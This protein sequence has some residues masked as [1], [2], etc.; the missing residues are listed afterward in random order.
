MQH[1][2]Q[3]PNQMIKLDPLVVAPTWHQEEAN[4]SLSSS[5]LASHRKSDQS[6]PSKRDAIPK[7]PP[8]LE[9]TVQEN[10]RHDKERGATQ[11][12]GTT[13]P[14]KGR[15]LRGEDTV[16]P[17]PPHLKDP[18]HHVWVKKDKNKI[19]NM[20]PCQLV[21]V[22]VDTTTLARRSPYFV[23]ATILVQHTFWLMPKWL[24]H[25]EFSK[26]LGKNQ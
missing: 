18:S 15:T 4:L 1:R 6:L 22:Y 10:L 2:R 20:T 25:C 5:T 7:Q 8:H 23:H 16:T 9:R 19:L 3:W 24:K 14:P 21:V 13:P 17:P 12:Q 26:L 11:H